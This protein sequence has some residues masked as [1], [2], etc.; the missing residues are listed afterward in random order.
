MNWKS[1]TSWVLVLGLLAALPAVAQIPSGTLAG[2]VTSSEGALPGVLVTATSPSLQGSRTA[3]TSANGAFLMPNLPPGEYSLVFELQGLETVARTVRVAAAQDSRIEVEMAI[4]AITEEI[5]VTGSLETISQTSQVASTYTKELVDSLPAGRTISEIAK[6]APGVAA[7]GPSKNTETGQSSLTISGAPSFENLFMVNGV[8]INENLRGQPNN[9]LIEDAIQETTTSAAAISAEYGRFSGGIVTVLT[10]SGGND[11]SGSLRATYN[12]QDWQ[13]Q[14]PFGEP[15]TDD[16]VPTYEATLGGPILRDR[17]WFFAAGRDFESNSTDTT[18]FTNI[19][20]STGRQERRYEGKLTL[21]ATSKHSLVASYM[22]LSDEEAGNFFGTI[23]DTASLNNRETPQELLAV[24]YNGILTSDLYL[25]AQYS[26]RQ[27]TFI[28][29]GSRFTDRIGGT[30]LID[31]SRGGARYHS[32]TFCGVCLPEERDNENA[33][34]KLNYFLSTERLGTHDLVFGVDT[35]NDIR[36]AENH[37]SGSGFR[38]LGTGAT[39]VGT[40]IFPVFNGANGSTTIQWNPIFNPTQGTDFRTNSLFVN[41]TWRMSDRWSFN[42]GLRYDQND[43]KNAAGATVADDSSFSPRLA[44]TF[45]PKS[46]GDWLINASYGQYVAGIANSVA[47]STSGAGAPA[48]FQWTYAGPSINV[49]GGSIS[50]DDALRQLFAWFDSEGGTAN[51]T[52]LIGESIPGNNVQ[53][54]GSLDSPNVSEVTLGLAKQLG[55]RGV[56]RTDL[57]YREWGNFY[58]ARTDRSTGTVVSPSGS[59]SDLTLIQNDDANYE[60]T[61]EALQA[62]FRYRATDRL[63]FGGNYTLSRAHG[64]FDGENRNSGPLT[65]SINSYPEYQDARWSSPD[66]DLAIDQRHRLNLY[67]VYRIFNA[68]QHSLSASILQSFSS[69]VPYGAVG[70]VRTQAFVTNPGYRTPPTRV[71]YYFTARDEF[72]TDDVLRTDISLIYSF[73]FRDIEMYVQPQI[74][75]VLNEDG[76]DTTDSRFL[77][78]AIRTADNGGTCSRASASGGPGPCR[79]FNP[80]TQTP[81]EGVN[82]DKAPGF[83]T[84]INQNG[85]QRA[86]T[87]RVAVGLRF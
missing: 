81:V 71:T 9:L 51:R 62:Q 43:G 67:G 65:G 61:Y 16:V 64:N 10:K 73:N 38:I 25:T 35:F 6:L 86:R 14:T 40:D 17:L 48:T 2:S 58:A 87:F 4:S 85:Y 49:G 27:F 33:L 75:N 46:D 55:S 36:A 53:I 74:L 76:V 15:Q 83:G 12:N 5:V 19:A 13:S 45:D 79:T 50:Q 21:A 1:I 26:E 20:F 30:L 8:V 69:G 70:A 66:G 7:T 84:P 57:V 78:L 56:V 34:A 29:S 32:P 3:T 59:L 60:R 52:F 31:N 54:R 39:I 42:L 28:G 80:F 63:D 23:M 68:D 72:R 41:D 44:V 37:Q 24:N 18:R 22:D 77:T 11:F 82:W 47:D